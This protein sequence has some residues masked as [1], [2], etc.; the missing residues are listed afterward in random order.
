[1][2]CMENEKI[3]DPRLRRPSI[4]LS[5]EK[6]YDPNTKHPMDVRERA[7]PYRR[8]LWFEAPRPTKT[9]FPVC[10]ETKVLYAI[11]I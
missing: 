2:A 9:V 3:K 7:Q 1:M 11:F 4:L 8:G 5:R 10:M 6:T